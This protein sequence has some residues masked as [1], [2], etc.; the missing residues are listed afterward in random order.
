MRPR[1]LWLPIVLHLFLWLGGARPAAAQTADAP[2][3]WSGKWGLTAGYGNRKVA[4]E[5]GSAL[6]DTLH[7]VRGEAALQLGYQSLKFT[8]ST[9]V[10]GQMVWKDTQFDHAGLKD[11]ERLDLKYRKTSLRQ[12]SGSWRSDFKWKPSDRNQYST[13]ILYQIERDK[14][15]GSIL[16]MQMNLT[17]EDLDKIKVSVEERR[18][19]KH[20]VQTGWRSSHQFTE[21]HLSLITQLDGTTRLHKRHSLWDVNDLVGGRTYLLTPQSSFHEGKALALLRNERFFG[22]PSLQFETSLQAHSAY[23]EDRNGGQTLI[24]PDVWRDSIRI[25][26]KYNHLALWLEPGINVDYRTGN[27]HFRSEVALQWYG[28]QLT[29]DRHFRDIAWDCPIPVGRILAEWAPSKVHRFTLIAS[30]AVKQPTYLQR[31]WYERQN[32]NADQLFRGNPA[33]PASRIQEINLTYTFH[34]ERFQASSQSRLTYRSN[35]VEQTFTTETID[36]R[37]YKVFT[38]LN[39]AFGENFSEVVTA[40]W[41]GGLFSANARVS[42]SQK[43]QQSATRDREVRSHHWEAS[44]DGTYRPGKGWVISARG[45]YVGDVKTLYSLLQGY[46]SLNARIEK[47]FNRFTL[48]TEGRDLLDQPVEKEF[49]SAD[50]SESWSEIEYLNRRVYL[51][52]FT[53]SF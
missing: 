14:S 17:A 46:C 25:Q 10:K 29:D 48:F 22:I 32:A 16:D 18:F 39:S 34:H 38:W 41:N 50:L 53:W 19:Q 4:D 30:Q 3:R 45:A 47:T 35:E 51:I 7:H 43:I 11:Q 21:Q 26:E 24:A 8:F 15:I 20:T 31:C 33:L 13:F 9:Q 37:K 49:A 27:W 12:P 23:T 44:A 6:D 2:S 1:K 28:E 52:G 36:G 40:G 42:Y 5:D